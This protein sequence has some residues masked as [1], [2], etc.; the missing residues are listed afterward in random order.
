[1]PY[2][3]GVGLHVV[4]MLWSGSKKKERKKEISY[5][6]LVLVY[7]YQSKKGNRKSTQRHP[8]KSLP[9]DFLCD[10]WNKDGKTKP[11]EHIIT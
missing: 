1:M 6:L 5:C 7:H 3:S 4:L 2:R 8:F 10:R 9:A 11:I